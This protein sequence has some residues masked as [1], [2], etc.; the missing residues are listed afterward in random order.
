MKRAIELT[1]EQARELLGKSEA[2]DTLLMYTFTEEEL[3][4]E[5]TY[6]FI[7]LTTEMRLS[8]GNRGWLGLGDDATDM[9]EEHTGDVFITLHLMKGDTGTSH[10]QK[11]TLTKF[12]TDILSK[13]K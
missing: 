6:R 8:G 5:T 10:H 4:R 11:E 13:L 2:L 3:K 1:P 9:Y 7:N 12:L